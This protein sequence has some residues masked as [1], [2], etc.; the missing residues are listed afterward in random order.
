ML[1]WRIHNKIDAGSFRWVQTMDI[2]ASNSLSTTQHLMTKGGRFV[3]EGG[4]NLSCQFE[5]S[6][7][8]K[9]DTHL[10]LASFIRHLPEWEAVKA[11]LAPKYWFSSLK[12]AGYVRFPATTSDIIWNA[13]LLIFAIAIIPLLIATRR[14]SWSPILLW[15]NLSF[16]GPF[17]MIFSLVPFETRYFYLVKIFGFTMSI[18]LACVAWT[19]RTSR[20]RRVTT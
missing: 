17:F 1:P 10:F 20:H 2:V 8:G 14:H 12:N 19:E 6:Y 3:V 18:L 4:G 13:I 5:T 9:T 15:I 7:C 16:F 11:S